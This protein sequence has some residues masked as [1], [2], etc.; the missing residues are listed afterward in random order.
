MEKDEK[1]EQKRLQPLMKVLRAIHSAGGTESTAPQDLKRQRQ[2][3]EVLGRLITPMIGMSWELFDLDGMPAAWSRP[4]TGYS[5]R[6]AILYCHGGGYTSGAINYARV[7]SSK[8]A[9]VTGWPVM[10]FQYRLAP[11]DPYPAA[12]EDARR[13][14]D[15]LMYQGFG[16]RDVVVAG[17]SAGGNMALCLTLGLKEAGRMLPRALILMSPW[18]DMSMSGKSYKENK[19]LDPMITGEYVKA[20]R[21]AYAGEDADWK[22]PHLSPLFGSLKGFPPT[23]VQ[24]GANEILQSDSVRLR[25]RLVMAG[26]SCRLEVWKGM[27]HVFQMF[28]IRQAGEAM[29]SVERFL[30]DLA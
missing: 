23:L 13:A 27:W 18:T 5:R 8:L 7:L 21:A 22:D 17:D 20:V 12:Q 26:S 25:D 11:E 1:R 9:H 24:V 30:L 4:E 6:R 28:P 14:W 3:H 19:D 29:D 2:G 16:A 15:Y 10:S